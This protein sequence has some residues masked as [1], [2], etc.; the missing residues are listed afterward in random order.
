MI[1]LSG[2]IHVF[3]PTIYMEC[4]H[5]DLVLKIQGM[6]N[7]DQMFRDQM[8]RVRDRSI[9]TYA[10]KEKGRKGTNLHDVRMIETREEGDFAL[11][12]LLKQGSSFL[13]VSWNPHHLNRNRSLL[14]DSS[15][16][17]AVCTGCKLVP[18]EQ[19]RQIGRPLLSLLVRLLPRLDV[20]RVEDH[21]PRL[22]AVEPFPLHAVRLDPR[23]RRYR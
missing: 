12:L 23:S 13:L 4:V 6:Q 14:V 8:F 11:E 18:Y 1:N 15:V 16:D 20:L 10:D 22:Q 7:E 9:R 17:P 3:F 21:R 2:K 5:I 19:L